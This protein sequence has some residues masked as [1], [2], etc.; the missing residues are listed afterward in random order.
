VGLLCA[1]HSR[2]WAATDVALEV[3]LD[4]HVQ[5]LRA[6][7]RAS[8]GPGRDC[9]LAD[10]LSTGGVASRGRAGSRVGGPGTGTP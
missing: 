10:A 3:D 7:L 9:A 4:A 2:I 1:D 8:P 6:A 5:A